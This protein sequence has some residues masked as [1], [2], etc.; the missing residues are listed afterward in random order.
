M[1]EEV[2][3]IVFNAWHSAIEI[4]PHSKS[5]AGFCPQ[6][7]YLLLMW[8]EKALIFSTISMSSSEKGDCNPCLTRRFTEIM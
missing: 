4:I 3:Y 1:D 5:K 2:V 8:F 7:L 6:T